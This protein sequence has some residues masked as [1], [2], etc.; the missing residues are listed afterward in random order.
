MTNV[1]AWLYSRDPAYYDD[2]CR[3]C[4]KADAE[5]GKRPEDG[6]AFCGWTLAMV[7][8][9]RSDRP[10]IGQERTP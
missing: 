8:K 6:P 9:N 10:V 3:R 7:Q 2:H 1:T 5:H 4:G